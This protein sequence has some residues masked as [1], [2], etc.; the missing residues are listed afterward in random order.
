MDVTQETATRT[1]IKIYPDGEKRW[2]FPEDLLPRP[3]GVYTGKDASTKTIIKPQ[4][5]DD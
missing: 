3:G 4:K 1:H 2:E 5:D